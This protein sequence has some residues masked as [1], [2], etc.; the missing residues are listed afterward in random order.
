MRYSKNV[1]TN[2]Y[3]FERKHF[4]KTKYENKNEKNLN[5]TKTIYAANCNS[6]A[7]Y[8]YTVIYIHV[9]VHIN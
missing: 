1:G 9:C 2:V 5:H 4:C 8:K 7:F 6:I 3:V